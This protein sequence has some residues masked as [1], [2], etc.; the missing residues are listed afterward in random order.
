MITQYTAAACV[1][2]IATYANPA[3]VTNIST[4]AGIEDYNSFGAT[5]ALKA[6]RCVSLARSVIAIELLVMSEAL[7]AHRP[8]RSGVKV[9]K[10]HARVRTRV[11][12]LDRDRAPA[13]DI[14][15]LELMIAANAL[16]TD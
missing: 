16:L 6:T 13:G 11:A 14:R 4:S 5:S 2:E 8:L 10:V 9:E 3:S 15:A 1:N 7:E 12:K